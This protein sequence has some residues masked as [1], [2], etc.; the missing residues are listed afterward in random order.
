MGRAEHAREIAAL[1]EKYKEM[2]N[3][4]APALSSY[5]LSCSMAE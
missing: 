3:G 5:Q 4:C 2:E 1:L